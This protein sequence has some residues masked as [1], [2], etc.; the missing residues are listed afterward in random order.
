MKV[1]DIIKL[2][3]YK[4]FLV[5]INWMLSLVLSFLQKKHNNKTM[6]YSVMPPAST[7]MAPFA[8]ALIQIY[9]ILA[10]INT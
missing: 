4:T 2:G 9:L 10:L 5:P 8:L 1:K 3:I 7:G 6:V